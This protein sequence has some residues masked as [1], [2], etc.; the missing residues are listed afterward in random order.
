[1]QLLSNNTG[2]ISSP[3]VVPVSSK[4][5]FT[6]NM[7]Q[8]RNTH[9]QVLNKAK[10]TYKDIITRHVLALPLFNKV[11]LE[12]VLYPATHR[13]TDLDNVCAIHNKFFQDALVELGRIPEDNYEYISEITYKFGYVDKDNPRVDITIT[14]IDMK[15]TLTIEEAI[16]YIQEHPAFEQLSDAE[17]VIE[18]MTAAEPR[19]YEK[20]DEAEEDKP[21]RT[22]RKRRTKAQIEADE[23]AAEVTQEDVDNIAAEVDAEL[24]TGKSSAETKSEPEPAT[25]SEVAESVP[26]EPSS[27]EDAEMSMIDEVLAEETEA[28]EVPEQ[29]EMPLVEQDNLDDI[30]DTNKPLFG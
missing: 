11:K 29:I 24:E 26:E 10:K 12:F 20:T 1:M 15:I 18:G 23:K 28:L 3:L 2:L 9:F 6:L 14:G 7:N 22:R 25:S 30:I 13:K 5:N 8:Y 19:V 21:K 27:F 16:E 4:R 17:I